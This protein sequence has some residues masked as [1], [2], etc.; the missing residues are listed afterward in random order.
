MLMAISTCI[1]GQLKLM[2]MAVGTSIGDQLI[3]MLMAIGTCIGGQLQPI[4]MYWW[5]VATD[6]DV[7]VAS[8]NRSW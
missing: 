2:L 6:L 4:L 7:L 3:L 1:G 8:C 5:P